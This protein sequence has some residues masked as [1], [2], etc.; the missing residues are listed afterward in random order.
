[1]QNL[2][3]NAVHVFWAYHSCFITGAVAG[4]ADEPL[5]GFL[6][7]DLSV[8]HR[9]VAVVTGVGKGILGAFTKPI[10]GTAEFISQA[11]H[12]TADL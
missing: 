9:A 11:G 2:C 12:G 4:L 6:A 1:M 8:Q 10:S 7:E 5:Q 3:P